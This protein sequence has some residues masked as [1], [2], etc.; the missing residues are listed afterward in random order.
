L[1]KSS[2]NVVKSSER[3]RGRGGKGRRFVVPRPVAPGKNPMRPRTAVKIFNK[4]HIIA[5]CNMFYYYLGIVIHFIVKRIK[6]AA[7]IKHF[8]LFGVFL[9]NNLLS[10]GMQSKS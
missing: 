1:S 10:K 4:I 2:Q 7:A 3:V 5:S 6:P 9:F 8:G